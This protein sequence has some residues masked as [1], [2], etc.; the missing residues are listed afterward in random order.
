MAAP[1]ATGVPYAQGVSVTFDGVTIRR[2]T[3][4]NTGGGSVAMVNTTST[5]CIV[6]GSGLSRRVIEEEHPGNVSLGS[7]EVP[8]LGPQALTQTDEGRFGTLVITWPGGTVNGY[9]T[10]TSL[11]ITGAVND[12][13]R[14]SATWKLT[15]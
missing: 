11:K 6:V 14:G 10:L 2:P 5:G 3:G 1:A 15:G 4:V 13:V 12:V 9:A 8:F 7:V